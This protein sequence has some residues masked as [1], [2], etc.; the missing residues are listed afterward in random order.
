MH[1]LNRCTLLALAAGGL[2]AQSLDAQEARPT[3][4]TVV[5]GDNLWDLANKYLGNAFLWPEIY[6]LNRDVVEDP[7]WIYPGEVLR[8][9]GAEPVVAEAPT[10]PPTQPPA[11]VPQTTTTTRREP[12]PTVFSQRP[13]VAATSRP[14]AASVTGVINAYVQPTLRAGEVLVAPYVEREGGPRGFG[15]IL[16]FGELA[17]VTEASN[18]VRFQPFDRLFIEPPVGHVAPEGERYLTYKLGPVIEDMGQ[19]VIPTGIVEVVRAART[20]ESAIAKIVR[21]FNEVTIDDRLIPIDTAG[22]G[23]TVRPNRVADGP[24]TEIMWIYGDPELPTVQH[25]IVLGVSSKNGVKMGDEFL[26][27]RPRPRLRAREG[28]E[29]SYDPEIPIGKA[30]VV[31]STPHGVTAVILGQGQPVIEEGMTARITARMP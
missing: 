19:V 13:A 11:G 29:Q 20:N 31:R 25:F 7:H 21:T 6:R 22:V 24:S 4:H 5:K 30:Q 15:R 3:S 23:T 16:K 17:G 9:P 10:L 8:L 27:Y 26:I 12:G 14:G 18:R 1:T 2:A 28:E